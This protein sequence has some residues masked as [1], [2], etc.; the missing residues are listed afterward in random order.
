M[1]EEN[2]GTGNC[3][4]T[5]KQ[6]TD[7]SWDTVYFINNSDAAS[8]II[9]RDYPDDGGYATSVVFLYKGKI[10]YYENEETGVESL[11]KGEVVVDDGSPDT[12]GYKM[13]LPDNAVFKGTKINDKI[14]YYELV[15]VSRKSRF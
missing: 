11:L 3:I 14:E 1:I 6:I 10:A 7:F 15:L 4:I 8:S 5:L 12:I 13:F 2:K 9:K